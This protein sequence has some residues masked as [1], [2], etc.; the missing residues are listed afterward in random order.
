MDD[1]TRTSEELEAL[2]AAYAL[3]ERSPELCEQV[4]RAVTFSDEHRATLLAYLSMSDLLPLAAPDAIPSDDLRGQVV[5]AVEQA[6]A[7]QRPASQ[8]DSSRSRRRWWW[9]YRKPALQIA[10]VA[11]VVV[12]LVWNFLL[13]QQ[14]TQQ[15]QEIA[16]QTTACAALVEQS[17][18]IRVAVTGRPLAPNA[19]GMLVLG[20]DQKTALL[21]VQDLPPLPADQTY[22]VWLF[23]DERAI[24]KSGGFLHVDDR[25]RGVLLFD[26]PVAQQPYDELGVT[27]EPMGG[28]PR[29]TSRWAVGAELALTA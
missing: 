29:P 14:M 16:Q 10:A 13:R 24:S 5:A 8:Q 3:G 2:L 4:L 15:Q 12:L 7:A 11:L 25:Q 23:A 27:I 20:D 22:Q 19:S 28:S 26:V 6:Q 9:A 18:P 21:S 1:G 17:E